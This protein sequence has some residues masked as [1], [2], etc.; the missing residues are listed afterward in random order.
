MSHSSPMDLPSN[1]IQTEEQDPQNWIT[2]CDVHRLPLLADET[3]PISIGENVLSKASGRFLWADLMFEIVKRQPTTS[4]ITACLE[5]APDDAMELVPLLLQVY[6]NV[7]TREER[8]ELSWIILLLTH[9]QHTGHTCT[10]ASL[11]R[12]LFETSLTGRT[13]TSLGERIRDNFTPLFD[14][15]QEDGITLSHLKIHDP[16]R[17]FGLTCTPSTT[18]VT[19][20]H[21]SLTE[22]FL[23]HR[24]KP[25]N[26]RVK[27]AP[28]FNSAELHF[29]L[30]QQ[31]FLSFAEPQSEPLTEAAEAFRK[32]AATHWYTHLAGTLPSD[33]V[34][35]LNL[36]EDDREEMLGPLNH[37]FKDENIVQHWCQHLPATFFSRARS[38]DVGELKSLC[39]YHSDPEAF[40]FIKLSAFMSSK[41]W[42]DFWLPVAKV[43]AK[44]GLHGDWDRNHSLQVIFHIKHL[45]DT[46]DAVA[47]I[48]G[49]L[50]Q[51]EMTEA[52]EWTELESK[53]DPPEFN[54][55]EES[56]GFEE[57]ETLSS[58]A[59]QSIIEA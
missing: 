30:L 34:E 14:L 59:T 55:K 22:Y 41:K 52:A 50:S 53:T 44:R 33:N 25:L 21:P 51:Q 37:F 42:Q 11:D 20:A 46:E 27:D 28:V 1:T 8:E 2:Y 35:A 56:S 57:E 17:A 45:V 54:L 58:E 32:Y 18:T 48:R 4:N 19:F 47:D 23:Q 13:G 3:R 10:L 38:E 39:Y 26:G 29:R 6:S 36:S 24:D 31:C 7:L 5:T 43:H 40:E 16:A 12:M 15:E 49:E 9:N